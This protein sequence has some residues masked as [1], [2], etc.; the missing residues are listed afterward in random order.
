MCRVV[1]T[2]AADT[3]NSMTVRSVRFW[4]APIYRVFGKALAL[5][6]SRFRAPV[7]EQKLFFSPNIPSLLGREN[8]PT[9]ITAR[10]VYGTIAGERT[11]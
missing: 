2:V 3:L 4:R 10:L 6:L 9:S 8:L 1:H 7:D 11:C 5:F